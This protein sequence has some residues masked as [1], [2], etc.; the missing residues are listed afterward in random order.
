ME[1][2]ETLTEALQKIDSIHDPNAYVEVLVS[3]ENLP[4]FVNIFASFIRSGDWVFLDGDLGSGKTAF[5]KELVLALGSNEISTSPTFSILNVQKLNPNLTNTFAPTKLIHMDLYRLNSGR[6]FLYLGLEEEFFVLNTVC[7]IEW[8]YN[9]E[10]DDYK[11]FFKST[12][13]QKPKRI[14]AID[15]DVLHEQNLRS[16]KIKFLKNFFEKN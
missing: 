1:S 7:I 13:C 9:I 12:H 10:I 16:Y 14:L 3:L 15:I 6:E 2:L 5:T 4:L 8:P 11:I